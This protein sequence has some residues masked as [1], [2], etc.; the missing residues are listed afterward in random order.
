MSKKEEFI[1]DKSNVAAYMLAGL[2]VQQKEHIIGNPAVLYGDSGNG[3]SHIVAII[4]EELI[5]KGKKVNVVKADDFTS[6]L[7][8]TIKSSDFSQRD[9]C[10]R[11]EDVDVLVIEDMQHLQGKNTT[12]EYLTNIFERL[13]EK[14]KQLVF[15]MNCAPSRL[16]SFEERLMSKF[17]NCVQVQILPPNKKM[18][19]KIVKKWCYEHKQNLSKKS[20]KKVISNAYSVAEILGLLKHLELY[21]ELY[22][23]PVDKKLVKRVLKERGVA[24]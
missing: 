3:K 6:E 4:R 22:E 11:Y 8:D 20:L 16:E 10:K 7:I 19:K 1:L 23:C 2:I 21:I 13:L 12:Q 9:F 24:L 14:D 17:S 5:E 18:K 15:T